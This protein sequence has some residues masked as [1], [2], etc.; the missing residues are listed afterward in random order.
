M[1]ST[2]KVVMSHITGLTGSLS[3]V[4]PVDVMAIPAD[5][6]AS[7]NMNWAENLTF[8]TLFPFENLD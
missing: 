7:Q 8:I 1:L 3:D 5:I 4:R 2:G 6:V